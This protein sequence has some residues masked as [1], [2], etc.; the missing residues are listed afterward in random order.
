MGRK[1]LS[2]DQ[3]A[4][5]ITSREHMITAS[6]HY[7]TGG[8]TT[9]VL[10]RSLHHK[11]FSE[12]DCSSLR[13]RLDKETSFLFRALASPALPT[14]QPTDVYAW[15]CQLMGTDNPTNAIRRTHSH[16]PTEAS[17]SNKSAV[18]KRYILINRWMHPHPTGIWINQRMHSFHMAAQI[19]ACG[20]GFLTECAGGEASVELHVVP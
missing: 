18:T 5:K 16:R 11:P 8:H 7:K 15:S 14:D 12:N 1:C 4:G 6:T 19:M 3:K 10:V 13:I 9:S 17:G 2:N 20:E